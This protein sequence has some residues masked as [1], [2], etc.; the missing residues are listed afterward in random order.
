MPVRCCGGWR[1]AHY[2]ENR[3]KRCAQSCA[4]QAANPERVNARN[5]RRRAAKLQRTPAW[6]NLDAITAIYITCPKGYDVDHIIPL[7]SKNVSGLHVESNL[8]CLPL[9]ENRSKNNKFEPAWEIL[10][11]EA[12][13]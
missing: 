6:R 12:A 5:A 7:Q 3:E 10:I 8:Q 4:N 1:V 2:T 9:S 11:D 13:E